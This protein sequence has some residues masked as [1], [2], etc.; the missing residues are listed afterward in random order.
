MFMRMGKWG[1]FVCP[2]TSR[3]EKDVGYGS[4]DGDPHLLVKA[5]VA[6]KERERERETKRETKRERE[7]EWRC[8]W[9][10]RTRCWTL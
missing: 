4:Q 9:G 3:R 6:C 10:L 7:R 1:A 5:H 2:T 8:L